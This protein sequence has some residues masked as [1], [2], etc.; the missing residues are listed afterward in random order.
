MPTEPSRHLPGSFQSPRLVR[1]ASKPRHP[2]PTLSG[3]AEHG[4]VIADRVL[5]R[6]PKLNVSFLSGMTFQKHGGIDLWGSS[7][8]RP[9]LGF[10]LPE[11]EWLTLDSNGRK[12]LE[13][14]VQRQVAAVRANPELYITLPRTAPVYRSAVG[15]TKHTSD[16]AWFIGSAKSYDDDPDKN[17]Y[18]DKKLVKGPEDSW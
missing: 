6:Y 3:N 10:I 16:G 1:S 5:A 17:L 7:V 2:H 18:L 14:Y 12:D 9:T 15:Y 11:S 8:G 13:A 4:R